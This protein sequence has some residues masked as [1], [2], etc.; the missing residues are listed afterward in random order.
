MQHRKVTIVCV[1]ALF[2]ISSRKKFP[3]RKET[4]DCS[5]ITIVL[6]LRR[7]DY[8]N[9]VSRNLIS[10]GGPSSLAGGEGFTHF[11]SVSSSESSRIL[12]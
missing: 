7:L 10:L 5:L 8:R 4:L 2:I 11:T 6:I 12:A 9:A 3:R 1:D